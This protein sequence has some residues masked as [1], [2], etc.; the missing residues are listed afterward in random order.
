M[1]DAE[2]LA[3]KGNAET[4]DDEAKMFVDALI[5]LL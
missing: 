5:E 4:D 3:E 1:N 2:V